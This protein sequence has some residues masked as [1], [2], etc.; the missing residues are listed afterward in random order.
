MEFRHYKK[1]PVGPELGL[2][3]AVVESIPNFYN[4]WTEQSWLAGSVPIGAGMPDILVASW[5]PQIISLSN[6]TIKV[7]D[8]IAYLRAISRAK[9]LTIAERLRQ[10]EKIVWKKLDILAEAGVV[11]NCSGCVHLQA[12]WKNILPD[13][14]AIEVKV[15]DWHR[16]VAQAKRN[17]IFTHKSYVAIPE[18]IST[19]V[20][21]DLLVR[22]DGLG[23]LSISSDGEVSLI[24]RPRRRKPKIWS[25][26]YEIASLIANEVDKKNALR[27]LH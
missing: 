2:E 9:P 24:K 1:Q 5:E 17:T 15:S 13:L 19:R 8:V 16:A 12:D 20:K 10:S 11:T 4:G 14:I 25:Y 27:H 22:R 3:K 18:E 23:V 26:Y 6:H 21:Q 7:T